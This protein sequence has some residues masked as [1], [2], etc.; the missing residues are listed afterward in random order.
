MAHKIIFWQIL[1]LKWIGWSVIV[2]E[3]R[4][5]EIEISSAVNLMFWESFWADKN[6]YNMG[7][8]HN[9]RKF[10]VR[11]LKSLKWHIMLVSWVRIVKS[12]L[13]KL[14]GIIKLS[15]ICI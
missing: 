11:T 4:F 15:K 10:K 2:I 5:W 6:Y 13:L 9:N 3:P 8:C 12:K 1:P 7:M 14:L